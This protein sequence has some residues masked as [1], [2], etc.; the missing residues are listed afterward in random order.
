[1]GIWVTTRPKKLVV[2]YDT[3]NN[4]RELENFM[5]FDEQFYE[6]AKWDRRNWQFR[7]EHQEE[8]QRAGEFYEIRKSKAK[9]TFFIFSNYWDFVPK[10]KNVHFSKTKENWTK[11][12][13]NSDAAPKN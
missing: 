1:L 4:F 3:R 10:V 8:L 13:K 12:L 5:K 7:W 9:I 6:S 2:Q 11:W